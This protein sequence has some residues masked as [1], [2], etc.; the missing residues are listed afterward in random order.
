MKPVAPLIQHFE[1]HLGLI[2]RGSRYK[3]DKAPLVQIIVFENQPVPEAITFSTLGLSKHL[4]L[5]RPGEYT[6]QELI[7]CTYKGANASR[8]EAITLVL[9]EDV[10][11]HHYAAVRGTVNSPSGPICPG[12]SLEAFYFATP[13]A[14]PEGFDVFKESEPPTYLYW[15]I[16]VTVAEAQFVRV[17]G[18][19]AFEDMLLNLEPDLLDLNRA[20]IVNSDT[21]D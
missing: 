21:S 4:L 3:S 14:Y 9:A 2:A 10:L 13:I 1:N 16:P 7:T 6:R 20:S 18:G 8:L 12:S 5:Y 11:E 19:N 15:A 17:N